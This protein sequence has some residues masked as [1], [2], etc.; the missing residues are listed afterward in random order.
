M[1]YSRSI[2]IQF[3][4]IYLTGI[5]LD[6]YLTTVSSDLCLANEGGNVECGSACFIAVIGGAVYCAA[7]DALK[8]LQAANDP[9]HI[10]RNMLYVFVLQL[11]ATVFSQLGRFQTFFHLSNLFIRVRLTIPS[12]P[13][14]CT[15]PVVPGECWRQH[16]LTGGALEPA[17]VQADGEAPN[18]FVFLF[19]QVFVW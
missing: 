17:D 5:G 3:C 7:S 10:V 8:R 18:F 9:K 11:C 4:L 15:V 6:L 16:S 14:L 12:M 2:C 19:E 13:S 1:I